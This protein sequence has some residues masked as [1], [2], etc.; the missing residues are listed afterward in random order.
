[1]SKLYLIATYLLIIANLL[2]D[3]M[4]SMVSSRTSILILSLKDGFS[5]CVSHT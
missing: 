4:W 3:S 2:V 5:K 1:M